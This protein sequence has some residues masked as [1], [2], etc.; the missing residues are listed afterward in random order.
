MPNADV[1]TTTFTSLD[2][3]RCSTARR[4]S[5]SLSPLYASRGYALRLEPARDPVGVGDGQAVDDAG[6]GQFRDHGGE[7]HQPLGLRRFV[8]RVEP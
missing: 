6:A 1:A 8:E 5:S 2:S 4:C 3:S 7:P